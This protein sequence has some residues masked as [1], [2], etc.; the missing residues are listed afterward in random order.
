MPFSHSSYDEAN[1]YTAPGHAAEAGAVR[2]NTAQ[3]AREERPPGMV[4]ARHRLRL[5]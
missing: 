5:V 4:A 3:G 2:Y 1:T